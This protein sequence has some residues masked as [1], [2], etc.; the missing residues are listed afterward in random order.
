M[1]CKDSHDLDMYAGPD[2]DE[3][4]ESELDEELNEE[5]AFNDD[6]E[7]AIHYYDQDTITPA[8]RAQQLWPCLLMLATQ[9]ATVSADALELQFGEDSLILA[10]GRLG[11][12]CQ[13]R[14]LPP[15]HTLVVDTTSGD[16]WI[17]VPALDAGVTWVAAR[18][19][20]Y[21]FDWFQIRRPTLAAL[22]SAWYHHN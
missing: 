19:R 11:Y 1:T 20:V 10:L 9:H 6:A 12:W 5:L 15:L 16:P 22:E 18:E 3:V 13:E 7:C 17:Q 2:E 14:G 8:E 4:K 21:D